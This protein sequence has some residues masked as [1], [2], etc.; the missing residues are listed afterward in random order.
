M[1]FK[2]AKFYISKWQKGYVGM[3]NWWCFIIG[4]HHTMKDST[5]D[6]DYKK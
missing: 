5:F 6:L 3:V 1:K 2:K 4:N